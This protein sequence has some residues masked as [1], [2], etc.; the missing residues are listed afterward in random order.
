MKICTIIAKNYLAHARVLTR[1]FLEHHPDGEAFVLVIDEPDG[2]FDPAIEPFTLKRPGDIGI[3][4]YDQMR[5]AYDVLEL[6]TAVK[7]WLLR[8]LLRKHDDGSGIAYL[9][10]DIRVLSRMT[11]LEQTL[12]EH[13]AVLTPHVTQGM[14]RDG[15]KP[16]ETD[17]LL[18]GVYNLGFIGLSN[19]APAHKLLDWWSERLITDC[20]VAPERGLFVDQRW[21]DFVPGIVAELDIF[22]DP[23]YNVAYW[24]LPERPL[25]DQAGVVT[26]HGRPLRFFHF[27]GY[28]PDARDTLSKHQDRVVID[29]DDVLRELCH[30]YAD[31]LEDAGFEEVRDLPYDHDR[32]PS[33][34]RLNRL[35]RGLYRTGIEA[36][37]LTGS[38]FSPSG[39]ADFLAWLNEPAPDEPRLSRFLHATWELRPDVQRAYPDPGGSDREEFLGWCAV[40]GRTQIGIPEALLATHP[41]EA[42]PPAGDQLDSGPP[43][44]DDVEELAF[45]VNVAGYLR[46]ELGIGEVARQ[47]IGALDAAD[48]PAMPVGLHAPGSRQ[49]H[50]YSAQDHRRP[51]FDV[52]VVCVNADGLPAFAREAGPAFFAGRH[53]IGVW[54]WETSVFPERYMDAFDHVDEVWVGS[55]FIAD[56]LAQVAPVPVVRVPVAVDFVDVA[57][58]ERGEL[59]LPD[60]FMFLFS[61]DY[62]S[63]LARKNP[64]GLIESYKTAFGLDDGAILVLKSING[65]IHRGAHRE[66]REAAA[67]RD[68]II[69]MDGYLDA[70]VKDRLMASCDCYV[71][72]HRSEGFGLTMAEAMFHR[73]P[74]IATGYSGNLDFM[75]PDNAYLVD[76]ELGPTGEGADPYPPD[77]TW[78]HPDLRH[79]ARLMRA[80]RDEPQEAARRAER[81]AQTIRRD[82]SPSAVGAVLEQRL[83]R[84]RA[85]TVKHADPAS[86][87][88]AQDDLGRLVGREGSPG[89]PSRFGKGGAAARRLA[90]RAMKPYTA[91]QHQV[92]QGLLDSAA[93]HDAAL[94]ER[95]ER[96]ERLDGQ[97]ARSVAGSMGEVRRLRAEL[98]RARAETGR[99]QAA[100]GALERRLRPP[101]RLVAEAHAL[102]YMA[103]DAFG[104]ATVEH[105]GRVLAYD[106][107]RPADDAD[108]YREFE[109]LFRGP[110][111]FIAERQRRYLPIVGDRAPVLDVGCGRGEFLDVLGEAGIDASGVDFDAGMVRR[112]RDKGHAVEQGDALEALVARADGSLG[113][114]FS[115][116]VVEHLPHDVLRRLLAQARRVLRPGGLLIAETVNPHTASALKT[117][118]VDPTHQHPL[119][120]ET[121]LSLCRI[122]GFRSAY[123]FHPNGT[124][125]VEADRFATG[126]YAVVARR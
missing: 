40:H 75:T 87:D 15:K 113:T 31:A 27:S 122:A 10:P 37:E 2:H 106:D 76:F 25:A 103:S 71:S 66:V 105:A 16:S 4:E 124:G 115:A 48:I 111:P 63:V 42:R 32:L 85:R 101:E 39:E 126:E 118:W 55:R 72:L 112:C 7:P 125:D 54:W 123:V 86:A 67:G 109:E 82:H 45:G 3:A 6:S 13:S 78:A 96:L 21:V 117:F 50:D 79:A 110:E 83:Q 53:T 95:T 94:R 26:T 22:R 60:G 59:D 23:T 34:L 5:S 89:A 68:D 100:A 38:L 29:D 64:L 73:R 121:M 97:L 57:P 44:E 65:H 99:V 88:A 108:A 58:L 35:L 62:N 61:Y 107:P 81:G 98:R 11:E 49:G 17:I 47:L 116:Q 12:T 102:P 33:G 18:A 20:H 30:A 46:S 14:P 8:H 36:G 77:G 119:F 24:N 28:S 9:D 41:L 43:A 51:P 93:R 1:S 56:A 84:V 90:L 19:T 52:N 120:P 104:L 92:N 69:L 80:V 114:V 74:V 70:D 91:Y